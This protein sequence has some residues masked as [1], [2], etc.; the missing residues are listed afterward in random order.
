MH[1]RTL[2]HAALAL[3]TLLPAAAGQAKRPILFSD[4]LDLAR[5][6]DPQVSPDGKHVAFVIARTIAAENRSDSD[7]W[8]VPAEGGEPR[9]LTRSSR[10]DAEPR[11]SP[12]GR[13]IAFTSS[14]SGTPQ[15]WLIALDGGEAR[16]VTDLAGGAHGPLW[17]PEGRHILCFS[18]VYPDCRTDAENREKARA[19]A[20]N[21]VKARIIDDLLYRHWD[22]WREATRSHLMIQPVDGGP[23]RDLTPGPFDVPPFSLGGPPPCA[24][25]PDGR[26]VCFEMNT[27]A[28]AATS[29]N[30]NLFTVPLEGG[31]PKLIADG[32]GAD[33]GPLYSPDGALLAFRSQARGGYESDRWVLKVMDR[34][35]GAVRAVSE[36]IDNWV[37]EYAFSPDSKTLYAVVE[38][39]AHDRIYALDVSGDG[40]AARLLVSEGSSSSVAATPDGKSLVFAS[41]SLMHPNEIFA[42][43]TDGGDIRP[44]TRTNAAILSKLALA[45][46]EDRWFEGAGGRRIHGILVPPP[47][48]DPS[49]K[50]PLVL[51]IHGGPQGA[52]KHAFSFRWNPQ[53]IAAHGYVCLAVNP[54]GSTGFGQQF[55]E[56]ISG[57]WGGRVFQDLMNGVDHAI[58]LGYVDPNRLAAMGGS[59]GGYMVNWMLGHTDRFKA[60]ISHAGLFNLVSFYGATEE[61]WFP[62]WDLKGPYWSHPEQYEKFSPHLFAKNMKTPTLVIH[63]ELDYRVPIGEGL[64][65]FTALQRQGVPSRLLYFPDEGHWILKP[66]NAQLWNDQVLEWL[67]RWLAPAPDGAAK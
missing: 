57:D 52:W 49:K 14:R 20:E 3:A 66:R 44:L 31:E 26:E 64:Q 13:H 33:G 53:L 40:S 12:D 9:Q 16:Q 42:C 25:S 65:L 24:V 6:S 55:T 34:R 43:D 50:Y 38:E 48:I 47:R 59:Y 11:W 22:T 21:K 62:E 60:F 23:A 5:V 58:G 41:Q 51:F 17:T 56:E 1:R 29:T 46:P 45:R 39:E 35:T 2:L 27:D 7:I 37:N 36:R 61:L 67:D 54:R 4:I 63:G 30:V 10:S 19:I 18:D 8:I 28:S 32:P 15:I